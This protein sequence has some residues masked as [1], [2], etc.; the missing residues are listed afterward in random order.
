[1]GDRGPCSGSRRPSQAAVGTHAKIGNVL[2]C[3]G[4]STSRA[5]YPIHDI[6]QA[7]EEL[8]LGLPLEPSK[9]LHVDARM[10]GDDRE[11]NVVDTTSHPLEDCVRDVDERHVVLTSAR[12]MMPDRADVESKLNFFRDGIREPCDGLGHL[13]RATSGTRYEAVDRN[14]AGA[15]DTPRAPLPLRYRA[16]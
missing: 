13:L 16:G 10:F 3:I 8:C 9:R 2:L 1:M 5:F 14:L 11:M 6:D 7:Q 12:V 15:G 4:Y